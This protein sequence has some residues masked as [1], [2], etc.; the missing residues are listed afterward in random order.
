MLTRQCSGIQQ[1][2]A[3]KC[4]RMKR[5]DPHHGAKN[6]HQQRNA[7]GDPGPLCLHRRAGRRVFE[8]VILVPAEIIAKR[9]QPLKRLLR[10]RKVCALKM[11][12][13]LFLAI[14]KQCTDCGPHTID[15][16]LEFC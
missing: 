3:D 7:P 6:N 13:V 12:P 1:F 14:L 4:T 9:Q 2:V 11:L 8:K 16:R 10:E 15:C 5:S